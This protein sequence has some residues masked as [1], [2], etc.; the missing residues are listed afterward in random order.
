MDKDNQETTVQTVV[1]NNERRFNIF[2]FIFQAFYFMYLGLAGYFVGFFFLPVLLMLLFGMFLSQP[3]AIAAG[4]AVSGTLAGF[5]ADP[6][7]KKYLSDYDKKYGKVERDKPVE[8]YAVSTKRLIFFSII[9]G[10]LYF[11]YWGYRNWKNYQKATNDDVSPALRGWFFYF[12]VISLFKN[13]NITLKSKKPFT[14]YGCATLGIFIIDRFISTSL[15]KNMIAEEWILPCIALIFLF[16]LLYPLFVAPVQKEVNDYTV[17]TLHKSLDKRFYFGEIFFVVVGTLLNL[18]YWFGD[19]FS[20]Q[21]T[22]AQYEK[23]GAS[24][25]FIYRH[26][27]GYPE[28]CAREGYV[29][30]QYPQNFEQSF[31]DDIAYL[32]SVLAKHGSS[33]EMLEKEIISPELR[34]KTIQ[35][36]HDELYSWKKAET[37]SVAAEQKNI[38]PEEVVWTEDLENLLPMSLVCYHFDKEGLTFL[39]N[40]SLR[41]FLKNNAP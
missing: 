14:W 18:N 12:S 15:S 38:M 25:G 21:L 36:I 11:I 9:S 7:Y 4:F 41:D 22:E 31:A 8:Y 5:I 34:E 37:I 28:Y 17:N 2:A 35:Q 10:G 39:L 40:S 1:Q 19:F 13:M 27:K 29:M 6:A 32:N 24:I 20:P 3:F 16:M 33:I 26:T 30:T 23:I